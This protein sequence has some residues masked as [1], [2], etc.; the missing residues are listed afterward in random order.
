MRLVVL[1]LAC[2]AA[3]GQLV[4]RSLV[5]DFPPDLPPSHQDGVVADS[6]SNISWFVHISDLHLSKFHSPERRSDLLGLTSELAAHVRPAAVVVTGDLTDAKAPDG[7]G[8]RQYEEEWR[9]YQQV[10]MAVDNRTVWIDVR[11]NHDNFDV[12]GLEDEKNYFK[13]FSSQGPQGNLGS[14]LKIVPHNGMKLGF[15]ALDATLKPV[16]PRRPFNFV[17]ALNQQDLDKLKALEVRSTAEADVTI[18]LGHY[19]TS[20]IVAPAPGP[21]AL[22]T[23]GLAYLCGHLHNVHGLAP[24]MVAR[25][26]SGLREAEL[27]D[28][29]D[30]RAVRLMAVDHG[31][32]SWREVEAGEGGTLP[33]PLVLVTWPPGGLRAGDR[34]PLHL[35]SS[36]SHIRLLLFTRSREVTV[37]VAVDGREEQLA[38][39]QGG[40]LYTAPWKP[41]LYAEGWHTIQVLVQEE[42]REV[43]VEEHRFSLD[44][45]TVHLPVIGRVLLLVDLVAIFQLLFMLLVLCS[46]LPLCHLHL[47]H[48]PAYAPRGLLLL[49]RL[50]RVFWPLVL[51]PLYL[52][53]G[54][55][56]LGEVVTDSL[57]AVFVWGTLLSGSYLP[58]ATTWLYGIYHLLGV[59]LPLILATSLSL[60]LRLAPTSYPLITDVLSHLPL[61]LLVLLQADLVYCF[62]LS[63]GLWAVILGPLRTGSLLLTL[64]LWVLA[65]TTSQA[66]LAACLRPKQSRHEAG[67]CHG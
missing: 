56:F 62:H 32:L 33:L 10:V 58:T 63:Y 28:W 64:Y 16:G 5:Y 41:H 57:G 60:H 50:P 29:K 25:H 35:L 12:P 4:W 53:L 30:N 46:V 38:R 9:E 49:A 24:T 13:D 59:H 22:M 39:S 37:T 66:T 14:Y 7:L 8:S 1:V 65:C 42:G 23:R 51:F 48:V 19:P 21:R 15:L 55:W 44:G 6:A 43:L 47:H 20:L 52:S 11:G 27:K 67:L 34:E 17:G 18:W 26:S 3:L 54:P 61:A 40:S 45:S 36:S 31:V 2:A